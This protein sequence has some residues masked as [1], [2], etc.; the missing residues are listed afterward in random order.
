ME[1]KMTKFGWV[2]PPQSRTE[3]KNRLDQIISDGS[4]YECSGGGCGSPG[5]LLERLLCIDPRNKDNADSNGMEIKFHGRKSLITLLHLE[6]EPDVI[7]GKPV[8]LAVVRAHGWQDKNG[9]IALHHTL[10]S[11]KSKRFKVLHREGFITCKPLK[12]GP[13]A[14]WKQGRLENAVIS[15]LSRVTIVRGSI[16]KS[17]DKTHVRFKDYI[18]CSDIISGA[19]FISAILSGVVA[20]DFDAREMEPG[21]DALRNHGTKLRIKLAN[22][23]EVWGKVE[24]SKVTAP[25]ELESAAEVLV[26]AAAKATKLKNGPLQLKLL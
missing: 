21:S 23:G 9:C 19:D 5:V 20:I 2:G 26:D 7:E 24:Y 1:I 11:N 3:L 6:C 25:P 16:Q 14:R 10:Y 15:K 17:G 13:S 8:M 12:G 4:Y 22:I 18:T